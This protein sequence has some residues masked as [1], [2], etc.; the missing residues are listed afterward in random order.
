MELFKGA[1]STLLHN[2][3]EKGQQFRKMFWNASSNERRKQLLPFLWN[4]IG[5][6]GQVFGNRN[7]E[8]KVDVAN[9]Y[10]L[11]YPGYSELLTGKVDLGIYNNSKTHNSNQNILEKLDDD[12]AYK[13]RV[14]AFTSWNTF[15]F[16]LNK[17][18]GNFFLNCGYEN[19]VKKLPGNFS[20]LNPGS[21]LKI[22]SGETR[23]D[24][25]TYATCTEYLKRKKPSIVFLGF[26]GTD[27]AGHENKYDQ[28]LLQ[29][30]K[31][32]SMIGELWKWVQSTPEYAGKT[33]FIITTDHGRGQNSSDWNKHGFFVPGSSN[34]WMALLG[35]S[36]VPGGELKFNNQ[37]Y[38][39]SVSDLVFEMLGK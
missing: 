31:A 35:P 6:Q 38:L 27:D 26:S 9:P 29:A 33:S 30:H 24:K 7:Y 5:E 16:I 36:I 20:I 14:A 2:I 3:S 1:D 23:D 8:N 19:E 12:P 25:I 18:K 39:K 22:Q 13:G 17:K 15:S 21:S 11:S 10:G 34:S 4:V 32:D 28:Y 37:L